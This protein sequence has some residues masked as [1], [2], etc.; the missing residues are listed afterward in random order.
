M[1]NNSLV[2]QEILMNKIIFVRNCKV[3][4]DSDL[5]ELYGVETKQLKRAVR[6]NIDRFPDDF[7]F[8]LTFEEYESLRSQFGT[9]SWGGRR[10]L[11]F[12]FTEQGIAM[13]S[14]VLHSERAINVNI[15]IMRAFVNLRKL[16]QTNEELNQKLLEMEKK[17][18]KQ[19]KIV[20]Q[21]LKNLME[22]PEPPKK[23]IGFKLTGKNIKDK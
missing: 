5:A 15:T 23:E 13:L 16:L 8:E 6:R 20:F 10:Y 11:P 7:M 4:L 9:S 22:Q 1:E 12:V 3:M 21:V 14:S 19:F 2:S 18:D 17:Y